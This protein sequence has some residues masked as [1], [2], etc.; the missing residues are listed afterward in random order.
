MKV[1][2]AGLEG[3]PCWGTRM[4]FHFLTSCLGRVNRRGQ[5]WQLIPRSVSGKIQ[6]W[7]VGLSYYRF[8][9]DLPQAIHSPRVHVSNLVCIREHPQISLE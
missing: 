3:S 5:P 1:S 6:L 9:L 7:Y 2:C 4:L 8:C